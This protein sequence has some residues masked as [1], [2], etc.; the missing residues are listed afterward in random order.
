MRIMTVDIGGGTTD[1]SI[2][3]YC[4]RHDGGGVDLEAELLFRDS[5]SIAG[6]ALVKEIVECVLLPSL[7]ARFQS[8]PDQATAFENVFRAAHD[9][10]G[11]K[12]KWA[13]ITK[14]VFLPIVRQWL[15]DLGRGEYGC[16]ETGGLPWSPDRIMGAEGPMVDVGALAELNQYCRNSML[17]EEI[18]RESDP[19]AYHPS[20]LENCI[21]RI[22]TPVIQSLAKY[23]TAFDVDLVTLSGKPSELPQVRTLLEDLLPILPHRIIQAKDFFAG[24]WYPMTSDNRINDA[25]SVTAV[26][27]ALYQAVK[28]GKITG[29][30]IERKGSGQFVAQYYWGS[31]PSRVQPQKFSKLFLSPGQDEATVAIQI[32]AGLGRKMLPSAAK[33]EQVYRFRWRDRSKW[34]GAHLNEILQVTLQRIPPMLA[35]EV[36]A[37]GILDVEGTVN[38]KPVTAADVELQLCTLEDEEFWLDTGRFDVVWPSMF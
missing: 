14:L 18:L 19:I 29:W 36:E 6:D 21:N 11:S 33:P 24:D 31:M 20:E 22:F 27:A 28:N 16:P 35:N 26:G 17:G 8:D 12:A 34:A 10:E 4:D 7:G 3:Q 5:S 1:I 13:R 32:G 38:G 37:L 30:K 9:R 25:K 15:R 23:I 2:V